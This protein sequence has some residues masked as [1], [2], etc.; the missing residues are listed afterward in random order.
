MN[1]AVLIDISFNIETIKYF[2]ALFSDKNGEKVF[3]VAY[4]N[5]KIVMKI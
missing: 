3:V 2:P 1:N 5:H 4:I